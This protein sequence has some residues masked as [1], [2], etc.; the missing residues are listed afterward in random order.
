MEENDWRRTHPTLVVE[1]HD[2]KMALLDSGIQVCN[3][4][5]KLCENK[6]CCVKRIEEHQQDDAPPGHF[7]LP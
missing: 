3:D 6:L 7:V 2:V 1:G 5:I 4:I